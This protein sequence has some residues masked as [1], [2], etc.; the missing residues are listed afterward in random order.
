[1]DPIGLAM[2]N[3]DLIGRWRT[4]ENGYPLNT[5]TELMDGT[6]IDGPVALRKALLA[7]G[8]MVASNII[9]KLL[10]YSLG[11]DVHAPDMAAVR[12]IAAASGADDYRFSKI[13]LG[14]VESEP[15]R[16]NIVETPAPAVAE[17]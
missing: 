9:E 8:D 17:R 1:M 7:K 13:V 5:S 6:A 14:I 16:L 10:S 15:F 4:A 11:R 12:K 2:E 3:F